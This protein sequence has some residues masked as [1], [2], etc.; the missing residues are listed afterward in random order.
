MSKNISG[1][2]QICISVPLKNLFANLYAIYM[3][4]THQA[5]AIILKMLIAF[6]KEQNQF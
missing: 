2:F 4:M 1:D 3:L 5:V 6:I